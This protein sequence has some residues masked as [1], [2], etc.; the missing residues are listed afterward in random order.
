MALST[1]I[2]PTLTGTE[3][4]AVRVSSSLSTRPTYA[5][6]RRAISLAFAPSGRRTM[7]KGSRL[8]MEPHLVVESSPGKYHRYLFVDG[9]DVGRARR[10][11][12][13]VLVERNSAAIPMRRISRGCCDCRVS[14]TAK[15]RPTWSESSSESH[16]RPYSTGSGS[17]GL[18]AGRAQA[19]SRR[20]RPMAAEIPEGQPQ[21]PPDEPRRVRCGVGA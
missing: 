16:L 6:G 2:W 5:G 9:L 11:V 12:Q 15:T 3:S 17:G 21:R 4:D 8:P 10:S 18:R 20:L 7:V 19:E 13:E 14:S 1:N